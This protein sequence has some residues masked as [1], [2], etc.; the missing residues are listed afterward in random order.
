MTVLYGLWLFAVGVTLVILG[1]AMVLPGYSRVT[2]E[3]HGVL[4]DCLS[5]GDPHTTTCEVHK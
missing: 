5:N 4:Y 2:V 3:V 1:M